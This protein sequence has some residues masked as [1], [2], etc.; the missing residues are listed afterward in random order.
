MWYFRPIAASDI[1]YPEQARTVAKEIGA[2]YYETSVLTFFG[3]HDLFNNVVRAAL[4]RRRQVHP[5]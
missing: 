1:V 4:C 5:I 3:I 2:P